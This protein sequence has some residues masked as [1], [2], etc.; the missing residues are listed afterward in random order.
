MAVGT[1]LG[2]L[3]PRA[4]PWMQSIKTFLGVLLLT[5]AVWTVSTLI[6][7]PAAM[8]LVGAVF[9]CYAFYVG[10]SKGRL[11]KPGRSSMIGK[12]LSVMSLVVGAV[13]LAGAASG[14]KDFL[15]PLSGLNDHTKEL[16]VVPLFFDPSGREIKGRKVI[17]FK[18]ANQFNAVLDRILLQTERNHSDG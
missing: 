5:T 15:R 3:L 12:G 14:S 10:I 6:S 13:Y 18:G 7:A 4:G 11:N 2:T 17:G 16:A 9:A 8:A 1:S